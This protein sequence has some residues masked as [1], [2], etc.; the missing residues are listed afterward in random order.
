MLAVI[1]PAK[2]SYF[3]D[4]MVTKN[5]FTG[6]EKD[7]GDIDFDKL[8]KL[9]NKGTGMGQYEPGQKRRVLS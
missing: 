8:A 4:S 9:T 7:R 2:G 3:P 6:R 1:S 5:Q